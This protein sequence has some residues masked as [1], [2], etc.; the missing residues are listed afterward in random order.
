MVFALISKIRG[1]CNVTSS[2]KTP[3]L[4]YTEKMYLWLFILGI[5]LMLIGSLIFFEL[6]VPFSW[7]YLVAVK[8]FVIGAALCFAYISI[9]LSDYFK[10][11]KAIPDLDLNDKEEDKDG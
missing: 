3:L 8:F 6:N 10:S 5:A 4:S 2:E 7:Y 9:L 1:L 11:L